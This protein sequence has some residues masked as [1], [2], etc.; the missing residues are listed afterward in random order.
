MPDWMKMLTCRVK[1]RLANCPKG[2]KHI[3]GRGIDH[4]KQAGDQAKRHWC[5]KCKKFWT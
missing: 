4:K 3:C 2:G 5:R 1:S